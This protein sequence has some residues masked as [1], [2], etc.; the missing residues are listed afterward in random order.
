M[1][2]EEIQSLA[3]QAMLK[4]SAST[5]PE[6]RQKAWEELTRLRIER[7]KARAREREHEYGAS[8]GAA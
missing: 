4:L 2:L 6:V 8:T 5:S 3:D 7:D 1:T